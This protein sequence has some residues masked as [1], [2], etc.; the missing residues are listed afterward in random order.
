MGP[1]S[2]GAPEH[3]WIV[4]GGRCNPIF[5]PLQ[6]GPRVHPIG[7]LQGRHK[8]K[9]SRSALVLVLGNVAHLRDGFGLAAV[10][11]GARKGLVDCRNA[12]PLGDFGPSNDLP[13]YCAVNIRAQGAPAFCPAERPRGTCFPDNTTLSKWPWGRYPENLLAILPNSDRGWQS[14]TNQGLSGRYSGPRRGMR[15]LSAWLK[16][17]ATRIG[18]LGRTGIGGV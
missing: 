7:A 18:S 16:V 13:D 11:M 1:T 2:P 6:K 12:H 9:S 5:A 4:N 10:E 15:L 14:M 17:T 8:D 3:A